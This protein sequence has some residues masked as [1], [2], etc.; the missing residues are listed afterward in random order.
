MTHFD[1]SPVDHHVRHP[2]IDLDTDD[3]RATA[4][5]DDA[6]GE[7]AWLGDG[8]TLLGRL[9]AAAPTVFVVCAASGVLVGS[10][11]MVRGGAT[12][13]VLGAVLI[14]ASLAGSFI[15]V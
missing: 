11:A 4:S 1:S 9:T 8:I 14:V 12:L 13:I 15:A 3:V 5:V 6:P 2:A 10:A 7:P